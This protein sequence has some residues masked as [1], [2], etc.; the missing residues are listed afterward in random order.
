[1]GSHAGVG[2]SF[3]FTYTAA[4]GEKNTAVSQFILEDLKDLRREIGAETLLAM[5]NEFNAL[6]PALEAID[7]KQSALRRGHKSMFGK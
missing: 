1:M 4:Q 6:R 3:A 5:A 2:W 7:E